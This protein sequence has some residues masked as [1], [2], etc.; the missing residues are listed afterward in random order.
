M[1]VDSDAIRWCRRP[2]ERLPSDR[3]RSPTR[4]V[5]GGRPFVFHPTPH[6]LPAGSCCG[7][8]NEIAGSAPPPN[9]VEARNPRSASRNQASEDP[10]RG[11]TGGPAQE[12]GALGGA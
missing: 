2:L 11:S 6:L 7:G 1:P 10:L 3:S 8:A 12:G 5:S 9:D 4:P